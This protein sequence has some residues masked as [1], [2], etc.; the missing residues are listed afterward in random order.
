MKFGA[1]QSVLG[2]PLPDA[3]AVAAE[4]GFDGMEVDWNDPADAREGGS[5]GPERRESLRDA[6]IEAV[7]VFI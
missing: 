4:L 6:E 1:M 3:F 5:L 7:V 2:E